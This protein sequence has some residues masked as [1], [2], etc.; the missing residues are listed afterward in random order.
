MI[1]R[2]SF[3]LIA[4]FITNITNAQTFPQDSL[5]LKLIYK[6]VDKGGLTSTVDYPDPGYKMNEEDSLTFKVVY[7]NYIFIN[8]IKKLYVATRAD[9]F[10]SQGHQF[11]FDDYFY[12]DTINNTW[13]VSKSFRDSEPQPI[14]DS[15]EINIVNIGKSKSAIISTFLSTG[16]HHYERDMSISL[17]TTNGLK[18]IG[19]IDLDYSNEVWIDKEDISNKEECLIESYTSDFKII[20]SSKEWFDI[21]V[22]KSK[23]VYS[24]GCLNEQT[25][26]EVITYYFDGTKYTPLNK[27]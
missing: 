17:I 16:N 27:Q 10:Y 12:L 25:Y 20:E 14:G 5:I 4:Y 22:T 8:N 23:T 24:K 3:L 18:G 26:K 7:K 19:H 2:I 9:A 11:G 1:T 6:T 13:R 21:I 15:E